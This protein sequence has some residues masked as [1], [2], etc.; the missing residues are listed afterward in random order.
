MAYFLVNEKCNGCLAC[1]QNCPADA[2]DFTDIG[3]QRTLRHNM[4]RCARCGQ[5]W[6]VCPEDAIEF[7]HL[8]KNQWDEITSL[9]LT[10]CSVCGETVFTTRLGKTVSERLESKIKPLCARHRESVASLAQAHFFPGIKRSKEVS[11]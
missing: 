10:R 11:K 7:Q 1:V 2:L 8:M 6:R 4:A 5:C 3:D 9:T